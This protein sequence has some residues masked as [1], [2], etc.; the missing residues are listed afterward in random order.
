MDPVIAP[1][2]PVPATRPP[3]AG[4]ACAAGYMVA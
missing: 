4:V 1:I 3:V 2:G